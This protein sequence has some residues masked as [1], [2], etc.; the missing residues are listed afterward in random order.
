MAYLELQKSA[1]KKKI[2]NKL[3]L[4]MYIYAYVEK[5]TYVSKHKFKYLH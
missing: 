5:N 2:K 3:K 4:I 1:I